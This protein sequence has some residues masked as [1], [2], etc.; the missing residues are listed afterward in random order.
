ML[1]SPQFGKALQYSE[2]PGLPPLVERFANLQLSEHDPPAGARDFSMVITT[3]SQVSGQL[4]SG[5][6]ARDITK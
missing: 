5:G 6:V 1:P 3:G 4:V 2:T